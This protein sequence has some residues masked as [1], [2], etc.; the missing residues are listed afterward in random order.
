MI[1]AALFYVLS[2]HPPSQ[3]LSE[4]LC[5]DTGLFRA[6]PGGW[7]LA[8]KLV[9]SELWWSGPAFLR[10]GVGHWPEQPNLHEPP[11]EAQ[12][13]VKKG[14]SFKVAQVLPQPETTQ[15]DVYSKDND[16]WSHIM[17][18][19]W[20][21]L[22]SVF[23][24]LFLWR[25]PM[26][27]ARQKAETCLYQAMQDSC[28]ARTLKRLKAGHVVPT[29]S[30]VF[31][32]RPFLGHDGLMRVG[33]L[34]TAIPHLSYHKKHQIVLPKDHPWTKLIIVATHK[35]LLH[36]G[37]RHVQVAMSRKFWLVQ[38]LRTIA[39]ATKGCVPC[40]RQ[41]PVAAPPN[42]APV[43]EERLPEQRCHPFHYTALDMAGPFFVKNYGQQDTVKAYF[44]LFTCITYRAVHMEPVEDMTAQAFLMA[45]QRFTARRGCP[46]KVRADNGSNFLSASADLTKYW[47]KA[48]EKTGRQFPQLKWEFNPPRAPHMG[49]LFERMIGAAKRALFHTFRF[50]LGI[51]REQFNTAL[52]VVEGILNSRPITTMQ[53][54]INEPEPL[55]PAHLMAVPP[56]RNLAEPPGTRWDARTEWRRLQQHLDRLWSQFCTQMANILQDQQ[57]WFKRA[58]P[59]KEGDVVVVLDKKR[60]GVWPLARVVRTEQGRDG[61]VRKVHI[62]TDGTTVRR[63]V[64]GL[65][66][67]V[68]A[69]DDGVSR[70]QIGGQDTPETRAAKL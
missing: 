64:H 18:S 41:R 58:T 37:P 23:T 48:Q 6:N 60:R 28:L 44:I 53:D 42:M 2:S 14:M 67:L 13:E 7:L 15:K 69:P 66:L 51:P 45:M 25:W 5:P 1:W 47:Q 4:H 27:Q 54:N 70:L 61:K 9:K 68:P 20:D 38:P 19:T 57:K 32:L 3:A 30:P 12:A 59:L 8:D 26:E 43:L 22:L 49:G 21:K 39:K 35:S 56:Y 31:K 16:R 11:P 65:V 17:Y 63:A 52:V 29:D 62:L 24:I 34:L 50:D 40:K 33:G 55:T 36:Q 46:E 10:E